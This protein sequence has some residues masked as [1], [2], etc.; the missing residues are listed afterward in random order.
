MSTPKILTTIGTIFLILSLLTFVPI[1][2]YLSIAFII[3]SMIYLRQ[4]GTLAQNY[5]NL[6]RQVK[7]IC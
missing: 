6:N 4:A 7:T 5:L 2:V 1:L 3:A